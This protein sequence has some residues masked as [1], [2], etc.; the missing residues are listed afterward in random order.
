MSPDQLRWAEALK[1]EQIHGDT[2]PAWVAERIGALALEG[3]Q[4]GVERFRQIAA[5]LDQLR[6][7]RQFMLA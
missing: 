7:P 4:A 2:A 6:E 1:I 3:D 5:R